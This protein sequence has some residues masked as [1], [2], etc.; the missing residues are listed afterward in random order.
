M[1]FYFLL[2]VR[3][4]LMSFKDSYLIKVAGMLQL[5]NVIVLLFRCL[6]LTVFA[7][8]AWNQFTG[9]NKYLMTIGLPLTTAGIWGLLKTKRCSEDTNKKSLDV[10]LVYEVFLFASAVCLLILLGKPLWAYIFV[11]IS[12]F[13]YLVCYSGLFRRT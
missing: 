8:W 11:A 4:L 9:L 5:K 7:W 12:V 13:Y 6:L 10:K 2:S 3:S 1:P